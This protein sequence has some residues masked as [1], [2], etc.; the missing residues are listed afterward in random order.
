MCFSWL[1][2]LEAVFKWRLLFSLL[3][4][5]NTLFT[6]AYVSVEFACMALLVCYCVKPQGLCLMQQMSASCGGVV[7]TFS[8][9]SFCSICFYTSICY[10]RLHSCY[11][12]VLT[13][14]LSY[15]SCV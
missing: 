8:I 3:F 12:N 1:V 9:K 5:H 4:V 13:C 11:R 2:E 15:C 14:F 10:C 6:F 7:A